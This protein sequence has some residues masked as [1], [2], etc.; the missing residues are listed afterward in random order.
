MIIRS[1]SHLHRIEQAKLKK[2]D[3]LWKEGWSRVDVSKD[4]YVK[5]QKI[6][7]FI[8]DKNPK[9]PFCGGMTK[10]NGRATDKSVF[11]KCRLCEK[12]FEHQEGTDVTIF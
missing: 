8:E 6:D 12:I 11:Y 9:C 3:R 2:L 5:N 1:K 4:E 10:F 7:E